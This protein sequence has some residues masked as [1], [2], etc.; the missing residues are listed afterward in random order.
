MPGK[1]KIKPLSHKEEVKKITRENRAYL[2][3]L[4]MEQRYAKPKA[5]QINVQKS[6]DAETVRNILDTHREYR[7]TQRSP[8]ATQNQLQVYDAPDLKQQTALR[9]N[10]TDIAVCEFIGSI[11]GLLFLGGIAAT[12]YYFHFYSVANPGTDYVNLERLNTR[13]DGI[14]IGVGA[15]LV[16]LAV[17]VVCMFLLGMQYAARDGQK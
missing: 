2:A 3:K 17:F 12:V 6:K 5:S 15:C 14:I 10:K 7:P 4:E 13:Q 8:L 1:P 11:G 9:Q 16:G